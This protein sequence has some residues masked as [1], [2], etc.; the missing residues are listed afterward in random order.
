VG[1]R[2]ER[3]ALRSGQ[4]GWVSRHEHVT[5]IIAREGLRAAGLDCAFEVPMLIP[6][7]DRRPGDLFACLEAPYPSAPVPRNTAI[8]VTIRSSRVA[9]RRR[10]TA[11]KPG[12]SATFAEREKHD[13]LE[14]AIAAAAAAAAQSPLSRIYHGNSAR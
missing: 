5:K 13:D 8:D 6:N 7:S 3:I 10:H 1:A 9:A 14:K 2:T 12:E 4:N 11:E